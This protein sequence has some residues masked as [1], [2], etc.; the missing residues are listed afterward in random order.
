MNDKLT[1]SDIRKM[2]EEIEYRKLIVRKELLEHVEFTVR[3][4]ENEQYIVQ[5]LEREKRVGRVEKVDDHTY[6][7]CAD[8]YDSGEM[9]PWIRTFICRIEQMNFSNR[10]V[11]NRF[12]SDLE[13][14]YL[15]YG[16]RKEGDV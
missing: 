3:V 10:T 5:R 9:L 1:R 6:R 15:M 4:G 12:K 8:V 2:E 16:I 14:M 7:F 11:E 13:A